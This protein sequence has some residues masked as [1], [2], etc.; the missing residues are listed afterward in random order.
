MRFAFDHWG[1]P[2]VFSEPVRLDYTQT[3]EL[4]IDFGTSAA[5]AELPSEQIRREAVLTV[6]VNGAVVWRRPSH[7]FN[8]PPEELAIG[9]NA[10]GGTTCALTFTGKVLAAE[11]LPQN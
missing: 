4:E 2:Q 8:T 5:P 9:R 7:F 3:H 11:R 1:L 10:I 6:R